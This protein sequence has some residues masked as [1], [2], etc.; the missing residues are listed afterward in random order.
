MLVADDGSASGLGAAAMSA[1]GGALGALTGR[2]GRGGPGAMLGGGGLRSAT[3]S[4]GTFSIANV[5][6][7]KYTIVARADGG[8]NG[9]P[10][11]ALQQLIVAGDEVNV[12]LTP[13][14]GVQLPEPSRSKRQAHRRQTGSPV[15]A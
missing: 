2:G 14:P 5:T 8:P 3:R 15:F 11:T 1:F 4:D 12:A 9:S 6:P 10:R 7:G 13:V